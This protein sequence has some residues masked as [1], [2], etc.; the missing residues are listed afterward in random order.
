MPKSKLLFLAQT[1]PFP[2]DGGAAIRGYNVLRLL[3]RDYDV[4]ALCFYRRATTPDLAG[5]VAA[6]RAIACTVEVFPIEQ[7]HSGIRLT[8]DHARSLLTGRAYTVY[9]YESARFRAA[10]L[11]RLRSTRFDLVHMDSLDLSGYLQ[12]LAGQRVILGHH[13]VESSLLHRRAAN[14]SSFPRRAYLR[15]QARLTEREERRWLSRVALNIAVSDGD[16]RDL[17]AL[18]PAARM[19]VVPNGVDVEKFVPGASS[20]RSGIAFVGG[21]SWFPNADALEYFA[22]D[23][24]PLIRESDGAVTVTWV[25]RASPEEIERYA[26]IGITLT[27]HVDDIRPCVDRAACYVVPLRIG[28]GTRLKILDG[29]AMGKAIVST[30]IGCEGLDAIDGKNILVRDDPRSFAAAVIAVL[31][32]SGLRAS[33]EREGRVTAEQTYSWEVI[34]AAIR[35]A[36]GDAR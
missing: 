2:P 31:R 15:H 8:W 27:G 25:G 3:A 24:L 35:R 12:L 21:M 4:T 16:A 18:A 7:E 28:G 10:L 19:A 36:Y 22:Q 17:A 11:D 9:A 34:G 32:D 14:E 5:S 13:N 33:L 26:R 29:W 20:E 1:L 30:S 6:L 23:I